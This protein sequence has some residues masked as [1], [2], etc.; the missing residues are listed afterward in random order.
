M[1]IDLWLL[2]MSKTG[3]L[4][5]KLKSAMISHLQ[6][7]MGSFKEQTEIIELQKENTGVV[8]K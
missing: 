7:M 6:W 5:V 3:I 1:V 2:K 4:S 8:N